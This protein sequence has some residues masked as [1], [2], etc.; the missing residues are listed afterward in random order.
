MVYVVQIWSIE[1]I[2]YLANHMDEASR[3]AQMPPTLTV[4][5]LGGLLSKVT[6]KTNKQPSN[7][8][9]PVQAASG[10]GV[11]SKD[12]SEM[13]QAEYDAYMNKKQYGF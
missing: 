13:S 8:P 11:V 9:E 7:L 6:T 10:G 4:M 1:L 2:N 3:I 5:E 12:P